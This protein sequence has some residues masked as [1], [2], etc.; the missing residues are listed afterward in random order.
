MQYTG[1][2]Y[3]NALEVAE[4][5]NDFIAGLFARW[6]GVGGDIIDFG[7]GTGLL[8]RKVREKTG[9]VVRCLEPAENMKKY[10]P[11]EVLDSLDKV[12]DGSIG[13]IYSSN[14]LEHIEDDVAVVADMARVLRPGGRV[15]LYLPAFRC[16]FSALD[17]RVGHYRRYDKGMLR[18]LFGSSMWRIR[19]LRYA[20]SLGFAATVAYKFVGDRNGGFHIPSLKFYDRVVFPT[21]RLLDRITFGR[22]VGKNVFVCAEKVPNR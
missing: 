14:V 21:S 17:R 18:V 3:L 13:F 8:A 2:D 7:A 6:A 20:D 9:R 11:G 15:C 5:Y 22:L 16:L 1:E 12:P 4:N 19:D 10:L